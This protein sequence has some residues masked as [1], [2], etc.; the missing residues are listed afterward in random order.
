MEH[1]VEVSV[2][3]SEPLRR[4]RPALKRD[5]GLLVAA[6]TTA[7][8]SGRDRFEGSLAVEISSGTTVRQAIAGELGPAAWADGALVVPVRW[9]PT[10][11]EHVLPAFAGEFELTDEPP[12][13]RLL[14]RGAYTV[15][16]GPAGRVGDWA[17]GRRVATR[18]LIKHLE[19][20]AERIDG[21]TGDATASEHERQPSPGSE[22]FI[23]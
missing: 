22:N 11:H 17:A 16:L 13:T 7:D 6:R 14:L 1:A 3:L 20:V 4:V 18:V 21:A 2:C 9:R 15:P 10:S 23:G 8:P 12:G 19:W 5:L